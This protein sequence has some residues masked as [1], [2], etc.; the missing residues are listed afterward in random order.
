M[1]RHFIIEVPYH[2]Q[3]QQTIMG[4]ENNHIII[5]FRPKQYALSFE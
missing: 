2:P 4:N 5:Y 1:L 3:T